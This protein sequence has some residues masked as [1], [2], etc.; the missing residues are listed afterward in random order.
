MGDVE[1]G[2]REIECGFENEE[3]RKIIDLGHR[4]EDQ[5]G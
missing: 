2:K 5:E 1:Q 3:E 4:V